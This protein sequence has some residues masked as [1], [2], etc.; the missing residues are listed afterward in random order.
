MPSRRRMIVLDL[1]A[2][3]EPLHGHQEGRFFHGYYDCYCYLPLYVFCGRHLLAPS[4]GRPTSMPRPAPWRRSRASS[5]RSAR[6]G[7]GRTIIL[8]A[9]SGFCREDSDGLVRGERRGLRVRACQNERLVAKIAAAARRGRKSEAD[10][11]RPAGAPLQGLHVDDARELERA[12]RRVVGKAEWTQGR[13][14]SALHR[15]LAAR[16]ECIDAATLYED[17][18]CARG[19]MENRIKECQLDLLCRPH[20]G[21]HHA[22]QP[23]AAVV[24]VDGLCAA[25]AR[26]AASAS[27]APSWRGPPAAP[28]A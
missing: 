16:A 23:A 18:Y 20:A 7:R 1:D 13:G 28:S 15:H 12:E 10:R 8:R 27:P 4:C 17:I 9:D 19:D 22:R 25:S 3:D 5:R 21:R 26:C 14:Q 24:R 2:T 6:A 11:N